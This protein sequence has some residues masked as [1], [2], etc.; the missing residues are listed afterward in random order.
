MAIS[1]KGITLMRGTTAGSTVSYTKLVDIKDFPDIGGAPEAIETTTL[2]DKA[3]TFMK[4]IESNDTLEFTANYDKAAY[5]SL[6]ALS[7]IE[8]PQDYAVYFGEDG[9]SGKFGLKG[10]LAVWVAGGGVNGVV[11]MKIAIV[12][13]TAIEK[14]A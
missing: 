2:S 8:A 12:P 13:A 6:L 4:G 7:E 1:T 14:I 11:E 10:Q 5:E 9:I 3:Q